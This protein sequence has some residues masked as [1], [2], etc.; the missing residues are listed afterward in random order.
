MRKAKETFK[1]ALFPMKVRTLIVAKLRYDSWHTS[2][3][4]PAL[5]IFFA[6][7]A[8]CTATASASTTTSSSSCAVDSSVSCTSGTGWSCSGDAQPQ[9]SNTDLVCSTDGTGDFCCA[10]S[11]C[12]YDATV[13]GC[14]SGSVGY[15]CASGSAPPDQADATL[16]CSV[17]TT[18]NG[19][20]AY[21]CF[22]NATA[23]SSSSTCEEDSSV[24][25]C[26]PDSS[27]NPSYGFSC[28]GSDTPDM[29]YSGITCSTP[30]SGTD[31]QGAASMLYCC[32]NQ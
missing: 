19:A 22:T 15:S 17:P 25:G 8:G 21:C 4:R 24:T 5:L 30:T 31:A 28:T 3:L 6:G 11:S 1:G 29:D 23:P 20:D 10:S 9:D 27:G 12:S 13:Q 18:V 2:S 26:Q 32:T 16:V 14:Q 7:L